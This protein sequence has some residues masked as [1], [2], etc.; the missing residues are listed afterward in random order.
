MASLSA[1]LTCGRPHGVKSPLSAS[2]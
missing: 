2:E 1:K